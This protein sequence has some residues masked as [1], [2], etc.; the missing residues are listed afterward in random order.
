MTT[1]EALLAD[2]RSRGV[3]LETDG[4]RMRWRPPLMVTGPQ[5]EQV[6]LHKAELI[7]LLAG[8]DLLKRCPKC[9]WPLDSH[10]R[11]PKCFDRLCKNCGRMTGSY[12][13]MLC[14]P[15]GVTDDEGDGADRR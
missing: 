12:F 14:M 11:C 15:C 8:P 7:A 6:R 10:Q 13:F 1:A 5:A 9:G 4:T 2:L 3:E